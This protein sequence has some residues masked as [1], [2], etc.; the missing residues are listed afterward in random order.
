MIS[1]PRYCNGIGGFNTNIMKITK[2]PDGTSYVTIPKEWE[3]TYQDI[4]FRI[5]TYEDVIHLAQLC[6]TLIHNRVK[7][8]ITIP[9]L[10]DAQ[11]D[12]RF[13]E[14]QSSG[15]SVIARVLEPYID[16][17]NLSIGIFHPHNPEVV[18]ALFTGLE[19]IDNSEF[20]QTIFNRSSNLD[21]LI[22]MSSDAGGFKPLMKLCDKLNW[23]GEIY[24]VSKS[25][26]YKDGKSKLTQLIDR[27][28]FGGK[29]I[30][31]IDDICVKGGTF[32]G[33]SKLLRERNCG[34]LYLAVSHMTVQDLGKDPVT[35]YFDKVFTTNSKFDS[36]H[37]FDGQGYDKVAGVTPENLEIIKLFK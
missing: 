1:N 2:Y 34:N 18:E 22:L 31:I 17:Y 10:I 15:L 14:F 28:D 30:L 6:D 35:N 21:D 11:A 27:E 7:A 13:D 9:C 33:L 3:D 19:I 32:K 37:Y 20:I 16:G 36:Y 12:R 25:R 8:Y 24:S 26:E 29:D 4:T 23:K 5:N